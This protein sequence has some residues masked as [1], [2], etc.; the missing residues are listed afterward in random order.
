MRLGG[1]S[2][3]IHLQIEKLNSEIE[4]FLA[5][6]QLNIRICLLAISLKKTTSV[7]G[8]NNG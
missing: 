7:T 6:L 1:I 5:Q 2:C 4:E 8:Y 3:F